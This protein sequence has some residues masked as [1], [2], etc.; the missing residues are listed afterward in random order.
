MV[1]SQ[2]SGAKF[3]YRPVLRF[4]LLQAPYIPQDPGQVVAAGKCSGMIWAEYAGADLV[5]GAM[6]GFSFD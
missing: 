2:H 6:L 5:Y 4:R 1:R 3:H